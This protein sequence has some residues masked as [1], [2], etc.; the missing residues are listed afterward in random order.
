MPAALEIDSRAIREVAAELADAQRRLGIEIRRE[1]K[2]IAEQVARD[3]ATAS[4]FRVGFRQVHDAW[5]GAGVSAGAR[6]YLST[7]KEGARARAILAYMGSNRRSRFGWNRYSYKAKGVVSGQRRNPAGSR[8]QYRRP[9]VGNNWIVGLPGE[10]PYV[11]RDIAPR[12]TN[13]VTEQY[14]EAFDRATV[15]VWGKR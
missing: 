7:P 10:G 8:P 6:L 5:K 9:W 13:R 14:A 15:K 12:I 2:V 4:S 11:V 3:I 1:H